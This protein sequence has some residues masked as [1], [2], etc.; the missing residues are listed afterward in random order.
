MPLTEVQSCTQMSLNKQNIYSLNSVEKSSFPIEKEQQFVH[1]GFSLK[2]EFYCVHFSWLEILIS[3]GE[4]S[5]CCGCGVLV[6][7]ASS[8]LQTAISLRG[9]CGREIMSVRR[10]PRWF[11]PP[12]EK[13][14]CLCVW[15]RMQR[16][17]L[18]P[19]SADLAG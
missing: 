8:R 6:L 14:L 1:R 15:I 19:Q 9:E 2:F 4:V 12:D 16:T 10:A 18:W 11:A 5:I 17:L 3:G 7:V 13:S